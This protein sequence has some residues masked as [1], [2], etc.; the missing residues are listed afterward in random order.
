MGER[1][2]RPSAIVSQITE[3][4]ERYGLEQKTTSNTRVT[5]VYKDPHGRLIVSDPSYGRFDG[6]TAAIGTCGDP[7]MVHIPG[8][9]RFKGETYHSSQLDGKNAKDKK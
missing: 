5:K 3:L 2:S 4:W 9:E 1:I 6:V 7:K 8:Q